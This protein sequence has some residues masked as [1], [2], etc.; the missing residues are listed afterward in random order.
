MLTT[1][2][3]PKI[4]VKPLATTKNRAASVS[5]LSVTTANRRA[6][7]PAFTASQTSTAPAIA[8]PATRPGVQRILRVAPSIP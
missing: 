7:W 4:S 3:R 5:P 2:I 6:S 1:R 8:A